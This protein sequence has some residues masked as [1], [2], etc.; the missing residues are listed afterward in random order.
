[1]H[2]VDIVVQPALAEEQPRRLLET[3]SRGVPV[4][5][6]EACGIAPQSGLFL[7]PFGNAEALQ[8]AVE[9]A[10]SSSSPD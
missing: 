1:L 3:L 2:N 7:V 6:T 9:K 5:A 4:V 10:L 8:K